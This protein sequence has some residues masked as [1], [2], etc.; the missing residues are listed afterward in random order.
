MSSLTPRHSRIERYF[1]QHGDTLRTHRVAVGLYNLQDGQVVRTDR[2]EMDVDGSSTEI[3]E[4][5]GRQLADIDFLLPN[6]D[7]LTYCL[8]ELD[9]GSLQFLLDNIDKLTGCC[10]SYST[11][12]AEGQL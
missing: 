6:D 11:I 7:D 4:L 3:P 5:I 10:Y 2:I 9:A 12:L 1:S 8:I